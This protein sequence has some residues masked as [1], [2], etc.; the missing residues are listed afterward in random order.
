MDKTVSEQIADTLI[1]IEVNDTNYERRYDL[2][3]HLMD[4]AC[5]IHYFAGFRFDPDEPEWPVA[6]V[7]LPTGQVSW[8]MPAFNVPYDGHSTGKNT[9]VAGNIGK[10]SPIQDV[11]PSKT[12]Y[13]KFK[14]G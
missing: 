8:H 11:W 1:E 4:L 2:I 3:M 5:R 10:R 12:A 13:Q 9:A 7:E 14:R 6:F